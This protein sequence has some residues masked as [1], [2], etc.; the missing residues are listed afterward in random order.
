M[1]ERKRATT[2]KAAREL[3]QLLNDEAARIQMQKLNISQKQVANWA[4]YSPEHFSRLLKG[5]IEPSARFNA[6][7]EL[8]LRRIQ[9]KLGGYAMPETEAASGEELASQLELAARNLVSRETRDLML[10][11][12]EQL[13]AVETIVSQ[14]LQLGKRCPRCGF[15]PNNPTQ[16]EILDALRVGCETSE[17]VARW[18][19][20]SGQAA[21][22]RLSR[23]FR[24]GLVH[25]KKE[26][27]DYRGG[28]RW[29]YYL[30]MADQ[31]SLT[32]RK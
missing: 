19:K 11:L 28:V 20:I 30:A 25:R 8:V 5:R 15:S 16:P 12:F 4:G 3:C 21:A 31:P 6:R 27:L 7:A 18:L 17:E 24:L 1:T 2:R 29:R 10:A 9:T 32:E 22:N 14:P 23:L 26:S 13:K